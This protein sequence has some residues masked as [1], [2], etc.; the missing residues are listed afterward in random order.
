MQLEF[1]QRV[2]E[3]LQHGAVA[4]ATIISVNGSVPRETGAKM[5]I[6]VTGHT[7]G[8]IGGGAGEAK[9][10]E[11]AIALLKTLNSP[12]ADSP[13]LLHEEAWATSVTIDLTGAKQRQTEGVCGGTMQVWI[14]CWLPTWAKELVEALCQRLLNRQTTQLITPL[15]PTQTPYWRSPLRLSEQDA[16]SQEQ[17]PA[18]SSAASGSDTCRSLSQS[19]STAEF[20]ELI[21]P[22]PTLLIVGAGH[23]GIA[24][25]EAATFAGFRVMVQDDRPDFAETH[26]FH[27][28]SP[29]IEVLHGAIAPVL[30]TLPELDEFYIALVTR[31]VTHDLDALECLFSAAMAPLQSRIR[32]IGMI[33]SRKRVRHVFQQLQQKGLTGD[34]LDPIHA[35]IGIEIGALTPAEIAISIC[36]E[37][38][39]TRHKS[40][41]G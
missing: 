10:I 2:T 25:A 21:R 33:G 23:V 8:T 38:I 40:A 4:I 37:L 12:A 24:L 17:A 5:M 39:Q 13:H 26:R 31:G 28:I 16:S 36:A 29:D 9:V 27:A 35:P 7:I 6:D 18:Q 41:K 14:G 11:A 32:Y 34:R 20:L 15:S 30:N 22:D 3:A 1:Y 19:H